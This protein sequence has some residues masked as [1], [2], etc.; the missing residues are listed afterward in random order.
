ML[1][2]AGVDP[3]RVVD[4]AVHDC[5][6]V[7]SG[8]EALVPVRSST[9]GFPGGW[10]SSLLAVEPM[11]R[12]GPGSLSG[13]RRVGYSGLFPGPRAVHRGPG[14]WGRI[15]IRNW[16]QTYSCSEPLTHPYCRHRIMPML[17][18][19]ITDNDER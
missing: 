13:T 9:F 8:A 18:G 6:G 5:V 16:A 19:D 11:A 1:W 10:G 14:E 3:D 12:A 17:I 15:E 7:D 4:V 2:P